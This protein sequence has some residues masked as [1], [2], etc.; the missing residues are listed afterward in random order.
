MDY[1]IARI[2]SLIY[3]AKIRIKAAIPR[4]AG[5]VSEYY[6]SNKLIELDRGL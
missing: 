1:L 5:G 4:M 6:S 2:Q 3:T